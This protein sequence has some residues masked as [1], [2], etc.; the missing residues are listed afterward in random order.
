MTRVCSIIR[1][2]GGALF[3]VSAICA[4]AV[5][6]TLLA[7][8]NVTYGLAAAYIITFLVMAW[9]RPD[10][11][12]MLIFASTPL[13]NDLS[14]GVG[15]GRFSI[16]EV[17]LVLTLPAFFLQM[18]ARRRMPSLGP[19]AIPVLLY[20]CV[21]IYS[22]AGAWRPDSAPISFFQMIV[23]LVVAVMVFSSFLSREEDL[24]SCLRGYIVTSVIIASAVLIFRSGYVLGLHKN[25]SGPTL[26]I[27]T[28]IGVELWFAERNPR[29]KLLLALAL[30][31]TAPALLITLSRG[32]WLG[33][34][35]G[36]A[37]LTLMRRQFKLLLRILL[38]LI[39]LLAVCWNLLP[40]EERDYATDFGHDRRN[41][42]ARYDSVDLANS[43]FQKCPIY[44]MGVGLRKEY[45]AT[46]VVWSTLAETGI[47]GLGGFVLIHVVFFGMIWGSQKK[48]KRDDPLYSLLALGAALILYKLTHGMVDHYWQ[49]GPAFAAWAAAGMATGVYVRVRRRET[50]GEMGDL[51]PRSA[52]Y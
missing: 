39:P 45:D 33:A 9:Q 16:A 51:V 41:I 29:R 48:L 22:S 3:V 21:C 49:R 17:N 46:N 31:V 14:G 32:A 25:A 20:L 10:I 28:I 4:A 43:Y 7:L 37:V 15:A 12:L 38:V 1:S 8:D 44:G 11:A 40:K 52:L 30:M 24:I 34:I 6:I 42:E 27:A 2:N 19:L 23:F 18:L 50:T 13:Q 47:L 26:A 5:P 35:C 36:L